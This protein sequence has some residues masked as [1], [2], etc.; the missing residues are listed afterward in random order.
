MKRMIVGLIFLTGTLNAFAYLMPGPGRWASRDPIE[1]KGG[2]NIYVFVGN[3]PVNSVDALGTIKFVGCELK[4]QLI[5]DGFENYCKKL[6]DPAF[7]CC[8]GHF[9]IPG[10]LKWMCDNRDALTIKC[11]SEKSGL[12]ES[13]CAWSLPGGTT[14][15]L[16]PEQWDNPNCGSTGCTLLHEMT[17]MI[18]H[19]LEKW[20]TKVEKCLGCSN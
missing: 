6:N 11:E 2:V 12:C 16:C 20:P 13:A 14:I 5:V 9:N 15:H 1:E 17:H 3:A 19:T 4:D 8:L 7:A 18:G 10:R